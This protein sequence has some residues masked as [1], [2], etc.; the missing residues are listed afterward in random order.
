MGTDKYSHHINTGSAK[1]IRVP[2][3]RANPVMLQEIDKQIK[4]FHDADI[5]EEAMTPWQAPIVMVKKQ[6]TATGESP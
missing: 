5:I 4:V 3:Y 1:P 6:H 2:P